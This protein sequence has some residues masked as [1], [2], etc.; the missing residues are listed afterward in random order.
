MTARPGVSRLRARIHKYICYNMNILLDKNVLIQ[1][2]I[3]IYIKPHP[4]KLIPTTN[5]YNTKINNSR[6][7]MTQTH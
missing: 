6:Y 4:K 1:Y 5:I 3:Y 7:Y 2:Y